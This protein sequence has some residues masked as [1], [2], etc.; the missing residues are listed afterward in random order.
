MANCTAQ[1]QFCTILQFLLT[2]R[3]ALV[4]SNPI[5]SDVRACILAVHAF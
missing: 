5:S 2:L 3:I 4:N 1:G